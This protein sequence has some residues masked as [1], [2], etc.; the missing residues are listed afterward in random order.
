M[1]KKNII[2]VLAFVPLVIFVS[3][4]SAQDQWTGN[5]NLFGGM[6]LLEKD[7]WEPIERQPEFGVEIDF[8]EKHWPVN[9]AIDIMNA[10]SEDTVSMY[11]PLTGPFDMKVSGYTTEFNVGIRKIWDEFP[12]FRPFIGGG[13]SY[14]Q[15]EFKG[16]I[17]GVGS[18]SDT[19]SGVGIWLGG[20][21][22]FTLGE[23]FNLGAEIKYS[24]ADVTLFDV[25]GNAGGTHYGLL[26]GY[27]W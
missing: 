26:T 14:I 6:K 4:A 10:R 22:Y 7:S 1:M 17:S 16:S 13:L 9:I 8:R 21:V 3:L 5:V 20:G 15:A 25:N 12:S 24:D 11:D 27:H 18:A 23:H 2:A 19:D